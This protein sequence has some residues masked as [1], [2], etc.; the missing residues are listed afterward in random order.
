MEGVW[1]T[2]SLWVC[3]DRGMV[4]KFLQPGKKEDRADCIKGMV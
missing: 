3:S 2:V 1:K 4:E